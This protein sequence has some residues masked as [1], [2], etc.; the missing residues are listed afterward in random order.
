MDWNGAIGVAHALV[1]AVRNRLTRR[2]AHAAFGEGAVGVRLAADADRTAW[3]RTGFGSFADAAAA[4]AGDEEE[5]TLG[6]FLSY[7]TAA[8]TEEFGLEAGR[9]GDSDS[10]KLMT[11]HAAKGLQWPVV[12]VPGLCAGEKTQV[13]PAKPRVSTRWTDNPRKL[14]YVL[15]GDAIDLPGLTSS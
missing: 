5:P 8:E 14:P 7:L 13:F 3:S 11:V 6:A 15:R 10:V 1:A 2:D 4:F 12:F 9:V